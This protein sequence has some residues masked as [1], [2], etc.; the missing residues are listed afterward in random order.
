[1]LAV[2]LVL[3]LVYLLEWALDFE[4][5]LLASLSALKWDSGLDLLTASLSAHAMEME[6][7]PLFESLK[8]QV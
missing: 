4:L 6:W 3:V 1:M 7:V 5:K 8:E 2:Y